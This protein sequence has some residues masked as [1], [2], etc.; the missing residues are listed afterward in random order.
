MKFFPNVTHKRLLWLL[1]VLIAICCG[2]VAGVLIG[3]TR[4]LPQIR[5][6]ETFR[7]SAIT[8]IYSADKVLLAELFAEKRT[9]VDLTDIP[10]Y[11][12]KALIATEDRRFYKHA[13]IDIKGIL[14]AVVKNVTTGRFAEG[15]STITQ[16][17]AKT[18]FL[19]PQKTLGRKIKE[20]LLAVQ[21]E[22]RYTKKE[23]L[24]FY[25]NQVY[26][27]SGA[28]GVESAARI[29][30]N[31]SVKKLTLAECA[32]IAG[33]PKAPSR[34]SPR[35][36]L[37]LAR[38]R[39]NTVLGLMQIVGVISAPQYTTAKQTPIILSNTNPDTAIAPYFIDHVKKQLEAEI[40]PTRLYKG[41]LN[42]HT[43]L[44]V[45][46]QK[47]AD[48]ALEKRL[49][50][51]KNRME[52]NR[53][54][55]PD[56]QGALVALDVDT[57]AILAL[58]GGRDY[59][60]SPFNRATQARRQPGSAFKPIL[61]AHAIENGLAQN[62]LL[63]DAPVIYKGGRDGKDW[64]PQNF[65]GTFKGDVTMR[66]A[67]ATSGNIPAVRLMETLT[68]AAVIKTAR[69]LGFVS[70]LK[71][72]LSLALGTSETTLLEI[73]AAYAAFPNKGTWIKP[74][75][76]SKALD[77]HGRALW[78][79]KPVKLA[80]L[81]RTGAA[82]MVDMLNSVIEEG[83]GR[84]AK[85]L[86]RRLGGKTGT[87]DNYRDALFVGFSPAVAVG[88][89]V[90]QDRHITLGPRE[91]GA[92]AALPIW[93]DFMAEVLKQSPVRY[94]DHP[95]GVVKLPMNPVTGRITQPGTLGSVMA[96]FRKKP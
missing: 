15:A 59:A 74:Y 70:P 14:R 41:G 81:S 60:K 36:N 28:Y 93:I 68:P 69:K 46:L 67:L 39:R 38:A 54:P 20:A 31:K 22:R 65:S 40:G 43:T 1:V 89:W 95:Q 83:T 57:G 19:T 84:R 8:R 11:L 80:A 77:A 26:I 16:Q 33:M 13:G 44:L 6:L 49:N 92:K 61:Y 66:E 47:A 51:L 30:F 9:L 29:Y 72:N 32:L 25:L 71:P 64:Q 10:P 63:Q 2:T 53:L 12:V 85:T 17:L 4:D 90:G 94:F 37:E 91:T 5:A 82:I 50:Q 56:P 21:L 78:Q 45:S 62:K 58:S 3:L 55:D 34:Y 86:G 42:I 27:G 23:I 18:L 87:T 7:P 79:P 76:V 88:V 96:L 75:A 24:R 73:T 35:V 52:K 48:T